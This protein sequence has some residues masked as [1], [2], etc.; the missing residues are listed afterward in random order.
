MR[1]MEAAGMVMLDQAGEPMLN[2]PARCRSL[3]KL[4][5]ASR[6]DYDP[7]PCPTALWSGWRRLANCRE[8]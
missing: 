4:H 5:W 2:P 6:S 7:A 3:S 8:L 1:L